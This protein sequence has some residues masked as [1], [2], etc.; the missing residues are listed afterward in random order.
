MKKEYLLVLL[1]LIL[2]NVGCATNKINI[3][4]SAGRQIPS[5]HYL[6]MSTSDLQIQTISYWATLK[7]HHDLDGT[8]IKHPTFIPYNKDYK[9]S[10][11]KYSYVTLTIEVYNPKQIT[12]KLI[13]NITFNRKYR[14]YNQTIKQM[15][16]NSNLPYRQ[17]TINLPFH[18]RDIGYIQYGVELM[19]I[20]D[21]PIMHFGDLNYQLINY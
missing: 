12:Y 11:K 13:E 3:I 21:Y 19:T 7:C 15:I 10:I 1:L 6:L 5:P 8:I 18:K 20:D 9:F 14:K 16:G 17:F 2:L 4:D